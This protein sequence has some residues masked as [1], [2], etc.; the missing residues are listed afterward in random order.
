MKDNPLAT[1]PVMAYEQPIWQAKS[2]FGN[3]PVVSDPAGIKRILLDNVAGYQGKPLCRRFGTGELGRSCRCALCGDGRL[4]YHFQF[5][6]ARASGQLP[7]CI[8]IGHVACDDSRPVVLPKPDHP[9]RSRP[10]KN[11]GGAVGQSTA[12]VGEFAIA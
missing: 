7:Q 2:M 1:I 3:Q 5:N 4:L 9:A 11:V 10:A 8:Q 12:T 6:H